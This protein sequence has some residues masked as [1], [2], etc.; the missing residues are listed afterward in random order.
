MRNAN[1]G[2][3]RTGDTTYAE[4]Q[5][6]GYQTMQGQSKSSGGGGIMGSLFMLILAG[7][8]LAALFGQ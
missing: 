4:H 6:E 1:G 5:Y 8:I 3:Y 2:V 7:V